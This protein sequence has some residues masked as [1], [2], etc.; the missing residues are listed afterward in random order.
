MEGILDFGRGMDSSV[1]R[2]DGFGNGMDK[3]DGWGFWILVGGWMPAWAGMTGSVMAWMDGME[4][5]LDFG[6][7]MGLIWRVG[8]YRL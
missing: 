3:G 6:G 2:N 7:A 1:R 5:I 8:G 4:G